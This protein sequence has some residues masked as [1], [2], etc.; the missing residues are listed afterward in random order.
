MR[1]TIQLLSI[2]LVALL[3]FITVNFLPTSYGSHT[4]PPEQDKALIDDWLNGK[5]NLAD[6]HT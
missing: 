6:E 3:L 4:S 2:L 5:D 1:R